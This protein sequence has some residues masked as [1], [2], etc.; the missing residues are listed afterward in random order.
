VPITWSARRSTSTIPRATGS[1][2]T[3]TVRA[4]TGPGTVRTW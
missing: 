1:S 2:S 3:G 4:A